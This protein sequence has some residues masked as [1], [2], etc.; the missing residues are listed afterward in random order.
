MNVYLFVFPNKVIV[1]KRR[2]NMARN[3]YSDTQAEYQTL[4]SF[5]MFSVHSCL[6][7]FRSYNNVFSLLSVSLCSD[8]PKWHPTGVT[9]LG[10]LALSSKQEWCQ[11]QRRKTL[12]KCDKIYSHNAFLYHARDITPGTIF[13]CSLPRYQRL[14]DRMMKFRP[15]M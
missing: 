7:I 6:F 8:L 12:W 10:H 13:V 11:F 15:I 14:R 2:N 5:V 1:R 3:I 9:V 4:T